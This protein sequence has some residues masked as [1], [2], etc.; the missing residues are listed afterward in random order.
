LADRRWASASR[1]RLRARR[2]L[3][4]H[5]RRHHVDDVAAEVAATGLVAQTLTI[6]QGGTVRFAQIVDPD[7]NTI[8]LVELPTSAR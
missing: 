5:A 1:P 8:T 7:G 6:T 2:R 3:P 4:P